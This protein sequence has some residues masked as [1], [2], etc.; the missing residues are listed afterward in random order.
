MYNNFVF[1]GLFV[2]VYH[3]LSQM[4]LNFF[5][6]V[7]LSDHFSSGFYKNDQGVFKRYSPNLTL[8]NRVVF[9][10]AHL[11][12]IGLPKNSFHSP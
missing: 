12:R 11:V 9:Y 1:E 4:K 6:Y 2:N 3:H 10:V 5:T 7:I 8:F